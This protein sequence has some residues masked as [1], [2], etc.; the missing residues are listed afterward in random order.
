MGVIRGRET[1]DVYWISRNDSKLSANSILD[2]VGD[3][4]L[5]LTRTGG[6]SGFLATKGKSDVLSAPWSKTTEDPAGVF[7]C[8]L[9][10]NRGYEELIK[11]GDL[12]IP[13]MGSEY[14]NGA[15]RTLISPII[16]ED[17]QLS[18]ALN[19]NG[20]I[21]DTVHLQGRDFGMVPQ[22]TDLVVDPAFV[23]NAATTD[24]YFNAAFT[25]RLRE[26]KSGSS[27]ELI[28]SL[29]D[30]FYSSGQT[31]AAAVK[32]QWLFSTTPQ[33]SLMN[34]VDLSTHVQAPMFGYWVP[35]RLSVAESGTM[36]NLLH[37]LS[38]PCLNEF[39]IDVRDLGNGY[40]QHLRY[41]EDVTSA[42][43]NPADVSRQRGVRS[44]VANDFGRYAS[45]Q[46]L[47][48]LDS[49]SRGRSALALIH[50][51]HPYDTGMFDA[52]PVHNVDQS[53]LLQGMALHRNSQDV[54]NFFR[55]RAP[56]LPQLDQENVYGIRID[57]ESIKRHGFKRDNIETLFPLAS[58]Q[59]GL[60][61]ANGQQRTASVTPAV[62]DY[63]S[64]IRS[65]WFAY[66]E[67]MWS[68]T[69]PVKFRPD[70]R[71]G[72]A[73]KLTRTLRAGN[74]SIKQTIKFYIQGVKHNFNAAPGSSSTTLTLVRGVIQDKK[75]PEANLFWTKTGP[76]LLRNPYEVLR[77]VV[78]LR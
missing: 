22:E 48:R 24:A 12:L 66:N 73:L 51:Q 74:G 7:S 18:N 11:P 58:G 14:G 63:Y 46:E 34:L 4:R 52:L 31:N 49:V 55:V 54:K 72:N 6:A 43:L 26:Q 71:V 8:E 45:S 47:K 9:A 16:V 78:G 76:R 23:A 35:S 62:Y 65:T 25:S 30:L 20:A 32:D 70:I 68:G 27:C 29:L 50:R 13:L 28:L 41:A 44:A 53:E 57:R 5:L 39:F 21:E 38:N 60:A 42:Y 17:V 77:D 2:S 64:G 69:L 10:R 67:E 36:W 61:Y 56:A 59:T 33:L 19:G 15:N 37:T 75:R 3:V 1:C 40:D